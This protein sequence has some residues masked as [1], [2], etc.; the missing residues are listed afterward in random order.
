MHSHQNP[1]WAMRMRKYYLFAL[2][3][4]FSCAKYNDKR[5]QGV[6]LLEKVKVCTINGCWDSLVERGTR[7]LYDK[8]ELRLNRDRS[9]NGRYYN[10]GIL[11]YQVDFEYILD[12]KTGRI[13][14]IGPNDVQLPYFFGSYVEIEQLSNTELTYV[15]IEDFP[16][17]KTTYIFTRLQ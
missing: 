9:A 6:W 12:E 1:N 14:F 4:L 2:L 10:I 15:A 16:D 17:D 8:I 7:N 11:Q 13:S 3:F 5:V